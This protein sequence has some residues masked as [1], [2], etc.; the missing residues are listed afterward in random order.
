MPLCVSHVAVFM[1]L[2][3]NH[4]C[5][6]A[7]EPPAIPTWMQFHN[8]LTESTIRSNQA[9]HHHE[10]SLYG[11]F[12][13]QNTAFSLH[14]IND[15]LYFEA[16]MGYQHKGNQQ[17]LLMRKYTGRQTGGATNPGRFMALANS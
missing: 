16:A 17:V 1:P 10:M 7:A 3:E 15:C 5:L 8:S 2:S 12:C 13:E 14:Y 11:M 4:T 9:H 6:T